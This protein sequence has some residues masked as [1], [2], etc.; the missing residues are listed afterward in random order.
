MVRE[1]ELG[2]KNYIERTMIVF[3]EE[4]KYMVGSTVLGSDEEYCILNGP[5]LDGVGW[6]PVAVS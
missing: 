1:R 5:I 4:K 6:S 2:E 3:E